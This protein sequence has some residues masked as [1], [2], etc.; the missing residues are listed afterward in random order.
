MCHWAD[1]QR[2]VGRHRFFGAKPAGAEPLVMVLAPTRELAQ[3]IDLECVKFG[4]HGGVRSVC[5]YGG[6]PIGAQVPQTATRSHC[7]VPLLLHHREKRPFFF[8]GGG[9]QVTQLSK[10]RP[11][12]L[13]ATPGRLCD[14]LT[15]G[16]V[17]LSSTTCGSIVSSAID[18]CVF[19]SFR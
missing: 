5:V 8:G 11:A 19:G 13:V 16:N 12:V 17:A 1:G 9:V 18:G 3:Q 15:R 7:V 2:A 14:L 10:T 4:K 6:V